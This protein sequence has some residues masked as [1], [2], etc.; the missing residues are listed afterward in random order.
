MRAI[1]VPGAI[2]ADPAGHASRARLSRSVLGLD[3]RAAIVVGARWRSARPW[4]CSSCSSTGARLDSLHGRVAIGWMV[5]QDLVTILLIAL[6]APFAGAATS[7][8]RSCSRWSGGAVPR[9]WRTSS[10]RGCCRG[11]SARS[12]GWDR[13]SCSCSRCSPRRCS[14]RSSSSAVF[15]LSLAL[16]AFVAGLIVSESELSHQAAG[17]VTPFRDLFAVLFFVSVGMLLDPSALLADLARALVLCSSWRSPASRR[18]RRPGRLLGMPLRS[19]DPAGRDHRPGGRVQLPAR[20]AGALARAARRAR[21]QPGARHGRPEHRPHAAA[22]A[23][24]AVRLIERLEHRAARRHAAGRGG[25]AASRGASWPAA[26]DGT[27]ALGPRLRP[28][29]GRRPRQRPGRPGRDPGRPGARLP[30]HRRG[31]GPARPRRGGGDRRGHALRGRRE[32]GDPAPGAGSAR[33][34]CSSSPS[35]TRSR[36]G[37]RWSVPGRSTRGSRHLAGQGPERG[38][39]R[40]RSSASPGSRTPRSRPRSSSPGRRSPGWASRAPSRRR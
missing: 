2:A 17:E 40:S 28:A 34:A 23:G 24:R 5:V 20:R 6:L 35:G 13:R 12:A 29:R 1:V 3:V 37:S 25:A 33:R 11:S 31:P 30:V 27:T 16:G 9:C 10:A 8:G 15:G 32:P 19:R 7:P 22:R 26:G 39:G 36:H 4:S 21:L 18:Q 38:G 14:P